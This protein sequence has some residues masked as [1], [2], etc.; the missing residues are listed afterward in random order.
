MDLIAVVSVAS[1]LILILALT[2]IMMTYSKCKLCIEKKM[3]QY[4][5]NYRRRN[6][7]NRG[8][9]NRQRYIS[10]ALSN[11]N[12]NSLLSQGPNRYRVMRY[13]QRE[14]FNGQQGAK[15]LLGEKYFEDKYNN[16]IPCSPT[17]AS[18][19]ITDVNA[20]QIKRFFAM[21]G[22]LYKIDKPDIDDYIMLDNY[23]QKKGTVIFYRHIFNK[24]TNIKLI[25]ASCASIDLTNPNIL[26]ISLPGTLDPGPSFIYSDTG[27]TYYIIEN[28]VNYLLVEVKS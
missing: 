8:M 5:N 12:N 24:N 13:A 22:K 27:N 6:E 11:Q 26:K 19:P 16:F 25:T 9:S 17:S 2:M 15:K 14:Y 20:G 4:K 1:L 23:D 7:N 28:N 3:N 21:Q 18:D 10:D